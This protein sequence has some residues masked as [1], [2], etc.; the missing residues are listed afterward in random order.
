MIIST[1]YF[2]A[3]IIEKFILIC[4]QSIKLYSITARNAFESDN[5]FIC[6]GQNFMADW[7]DIFLK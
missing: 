5:T 4:I 6:F 7:L 1:A 3:V 2:V